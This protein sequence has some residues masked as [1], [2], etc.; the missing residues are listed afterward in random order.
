MLGQILDWAWLGCGVVRKFDG[1]EKN[2]VGKWAGNFVGR[3]NIEVKQGQ[4]QQIRSGSTKEVV[5]V[6]GLLVVGYAGMLLGP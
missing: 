5:V 6:V 3:M 4:V 1:E 2:G